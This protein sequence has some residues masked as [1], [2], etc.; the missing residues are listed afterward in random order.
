MPVCWAPSPDHRYLAY[1]LNESGGLEATLYILD[2]ATGA[3]LPET[4]FPV[5]WSVVW[6]NDS[7]VI[8]YVRQD[9][10]RRPSA[11]YRHRL[12]TDPAGDTMLYQEDDEV[13]RLHLTS[14]N[15]RSYLFLLS[16]SHESSEERFLSLSGPGD[17]APALFAP[18]GPA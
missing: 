6:S 8:F 5:A 11:L 13:F 9:E 3:R 15:D 16:H 10:A 4:F 14:A 18:A 12:G 17:G 2:L 7:S 1:G